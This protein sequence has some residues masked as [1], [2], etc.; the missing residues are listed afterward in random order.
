MLG[1]GRIWEHLRDYGETA[2]L[3]RV[4]RLMHA[5][6]LKGFP[7]KKKHCK[8]GS[9]TRPYNV[10]NHL[11]SD[12]AADEPST[13]RTTDITYIPVVGR[14]WLYLCVVVEMCLGVV[15]GCWMGRC[16]NR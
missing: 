7:Y 4:A 16:Q 9:G 13:K 5:E 1:A 15:V 14:L 6:G 12:F 8:K 3:N 2:S 11:A 10:E